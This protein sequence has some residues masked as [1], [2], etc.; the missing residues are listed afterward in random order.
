M[1][2]WTDGSGGGRR[3]S[4]AD[5]HQHVHGLTGHQRRSHRHCEHARP[6]VVLRPQ[7]V[8]QHGP[9]VQPSPHPLY[10]STSSEFQMVL[11]ARYGCSTTASSSLPL[12]L[13]SVPEGPSTLA[14]CATITSCSA[15]CHST[16]SEFQIVLHHGLEL[17]YHN[18]V[19]ASTQ[20]VL[21]HGPAVVLRE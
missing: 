18:I 9:T 6:A 2:K 5:G 1:W 10:Q 11:Q 4:T 20:T 3:Q 16:S 8:L 19:L 15:G 21:H 14:S 7:T 17:C 12:R 13:Q